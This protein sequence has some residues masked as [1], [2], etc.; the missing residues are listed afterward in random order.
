MADITAALVRELRE[1]SGAGMMECKKALVATE[2]DLEKAFDE[3]RKSGLKTAAKKAGRDTGEGRVCTSISEDGKR[4]AMVS[5]SCETDFVA[6]TPDFEG[7]MADLAAHVLENEPAD[8]EA[9]LAQTW[10]GEGTVADAIKLLIG[11]LGEN[12]QI[13]DVGFYSNPGGA[14][15]SYVHHDQM[16]GGFVNVTTG[17]PDA[18][19]L[20]DLCMHIVVY[21]PGALNRDTIS[22]ESI[23]REKEIIKEGLKGKPENIQEKIMAGQLEKFFAQQVITEQPWVKDDKTTVQKALEAAMGAGTTLDG[24]RRFAVGAGA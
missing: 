1:K 11:R 14:V 6:K 17:S 7:F 5:I 9:C 24:F 21:K 4:G 13:A 16:Q 12:I 10:K 2:G 3:L 23:E 22:A 8:L 15:A 20:K 18:G 19:A